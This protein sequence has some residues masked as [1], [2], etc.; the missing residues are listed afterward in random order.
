[1]APS[2]TGPVRRLEEALARRGWR[3]RLD[4]GTLDPDGR[5]RLD[6][7]LR[8]AL[9][10]AGLPAGDA[11]LAEAREALYSEACRRQF[12]YRFPAPRPE[13]GLLATYFFP[14]AREVIAEQAADQG[15]GIATRLPF[16]PLTEPEIRRWPS[17]A[18]YRK[19]LHHLEQDGVE[20]C[21]AMAQEWRGLS[22]QDHVL[23]VTGLGL[24]LGRQ[25]AR[26]VPVDL[27]LLH[28]A[29]IGHDVG[30]FGCL[31]DEVRRIPRLHYYYTHLWYQ[32]RGLPGLGHIATNHSCWDLE[33]M[34]LPVETQLLVYADFRVKDSRGPD[35][36][37]RMAIIPLKQAYDTILG[38]LEDVDRAKVRRYEGVYRKLRDL[39]EYMQVLGVDLDPPGFPPAPP[40]APKL[41]E[42]LDL[43][44]TL[45]GARRP[46]AAAL[47]CGPGRSKLLR[48]FATAHTL[49]VME[50]LRDR[51]ALQALL[52]EARSTVHWRDVRTYQAILGDYSP[53]LSTE[54]K[55]LALRFFVG[56]LSHPDDDIRYHAA[57]RIGDLLASRED[58]WRK[59]LPEGVVLREERRVL[60]EL[61]RVLDLLDLA[62]P[63]EEEGMAAT[64]KI[65]Y[66]VPIVVRRLLKRLDPPMRA[67]AFDLIRE[68]FAKR[69]D[70]PRPLVGLY[71]CESA[72]G[73]LPLL[74]P[75][76][77]PDLLRFARAFMDHPVVNTRLMAWRVL[78]ALAKSE[79]AG[80]EVR[81]GLRESLREIAWGASGGSL[82]AELF[83]TT[84]LAVAC[85]EPEIAAQCREL[86]FGGR[87]PVREVLLRN[88]KTRVGWVEKK[89]NCDWL[90]AM[91][92][93]RSAERSDPGSYFAHEVAGHFAN[94][95]KV[96]R[97]EG[98][99]FHAGRCLLRILPLLSEPQRN[100]VMVELLRSLELDA[101][102]VTRYI[103]RFLGAVLSSL[104]EQEFLE[105][106]DD[107]SAN[108]RRGAESLQRLL[109]QT[110]GW[111]ILTLP[112]DLL[113]GAVLGRLAG[114]LLGSLAESRSNTVNEGFA[115]FAMVLERLVRQ[116]A[117]DGRLAEF[118]DAVTKK[119]LT[120]IH[121]R[122]GDRVR[123][124]LV[125][126]AL[127]W[128]ER[129]AGRARGSGK[130]GAPVPAVALIPGTFDP[131]TNAHAALVAR[132]L[133]HAGEVLVQLDDYSWRKHALPR[134]TREELARMALASIPNAFLAPF[135]PPV[136]LARPAGL[137]R[138]RRLVGRRR[139]LLVVGSD[140]VTGASAYA[141]PASP[142]WDIPHLVAVR[143]GAE[144]EFAE[145]LRRKF[146][147]GVSL[148]TVPGNVEGLSSTSVRAALDRG[149]DPDRFCH[150]LV[151][152]TL[153]D[154]GLYVNH[155]TQKVS[156]AGPA[157]R[158]SIADRD[159]RIP[160]GLDAVVSAEYPARRGGGS[161]ERIVGRLES[162]DGERRVLAA[163]VWRQVSAAALPVVAGDARLAEVAGGRLLGQGAL[164]ESVALDGRAGAGP[165][166][167]RLFAEATASWL[168]AGLLF[169]LVPVREEEGALCDAL[170]ETGAAPAEAGEAARGFAVLRLT[171]PLVLVWDLEQVLQPACAASLP[172]RRALLANRSALTAFFARLS[173]GQ[174][175]LHIREDE[176]KRRVSSL[177]RQRISE[178][179]SGRRRVVLGLGR[180]FS[181]DL[182]GDSPTLAVDLER[183]LTWQGHE[184]GTHPGRGGPP[185]RDQLAI[186]RELSR[187]AIL[188]APFLPDPEPVFAVVDAAASVGLAIHEVLIG[189][190]DAATRAA[191]R[192]RGVRHE[193]GTVVPGWR[194][195][196]RES[197][198]APYLGGTSILG[199]DQLEWGSLLPSL[200]NCLPY[201]HPHDL[202]L[203]DTTAL[204][205]SRLALS[206]T[207]ELFRAIEETFREAEGRLLSVSDLAHV[208]RR[209]RCPPFPQGF[210]PPAERFPSDLI[211]EDLEALAR[212][213][214][215]GH[216]AHAPDGREP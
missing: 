137:E 60:D 75:S 3:T 96:S 12:P 160:A 57:N 52:E 139:L 187:E 148:V 183:H 112:R 134:E 180:E 146:R 88:L 172:V 147:G 114:I 70:D 34:R 72:E 97:V 42:G 196:L 177:A 191:L 87:D 81:E 126:S 59:D 156:A 18:E 190:T 184:A 91:T 47:A 95:L 28:G 90:C 166:L 64:E 211:A 77:Y 203:D 149:E 168:D 51:P 101:E 107:I 164:V 108:V 8:I 181:R 140:V 165:R 35:G 19:L 45:S 78:T 206:R 151:A 49:G 99:R 103:P 105:A 104:P 56:L 123:F 179:K 144:R 117:G 5:R 82:V 204:D 38:K 23:G 199:R 61:D 198:V 26:S 94:L 86:S 119:F 44:G 25:L 163:I 33:L 138:L 127:N 189:V 122:P 24:H 212:L 167:S 157:D 129:A 141:D 186:A 205:F 98:T 41:P 37:P 36:R 152:R 210:V 197:S 143:A 1:M 83:L 120:L 22:I 14:L 155:P 125:A 201:H 213:H 89:V 40:R 175:L 169:A 106:L 161:W 113:R 195:V 193:A 85:G 30:K 9:D 110:V 202:G 176:L 135:R 6:T 194:G 133:E 121:H 124:F 46:D 93:H 31:G 80:P 142:V 159:G 55:G 4:P 58:F 150:P 53:A 20:V 29:A 32:D 182:V 69:L 17:G 130:R 39:E 154:R 118:T 92:E 68:D 62:A 207:R 116:P 145:P 67:Q 11:D 79:H 171:N 214:P 208:V 27:P 43:L 188:L 10:L 16:L 48:L 216:A 63:G 100:D 131:F 7:A 54:Q 13:T 162:A 209:P 2:E 185:L 74:E 65:I 115:Q 136:N 111:V 178:S 173:P 15:E 50:R 153:M 109:L 73:A 21:L 170:C 71:V 76:S 66:A 102:A 128:L 200:N 84:E 192:L 132:A 174:A 158:F 215:E